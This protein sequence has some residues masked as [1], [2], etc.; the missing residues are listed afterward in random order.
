MNLLASLDPKIIKSCPSS[1]NFNKFWIFISFFLL[2]IKV[3]A[4]NIILSYKY[5]PKFVNLISLSKAILK[6]IS[7]PIFIICFHNKEFVSI[8]F[9]SSKRIKVFLDW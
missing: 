5:S 4:K 6:S 3:G 2:S 9:Q 1:M 7:Y 8:L